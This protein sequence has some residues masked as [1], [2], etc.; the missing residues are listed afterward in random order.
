MNLDDL[1]DKYTLK[2]KNVSIIILGR[3]DKYESTNM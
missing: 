2:F 3:V 1:C